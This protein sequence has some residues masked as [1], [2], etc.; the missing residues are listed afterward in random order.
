MVGSNSAQQTVVQDLS[1]CVCDTT[2]NVKLLLKEALGFIETMHCY[3][4]SSLKLV[5]L[6]NQ[7]YT[8]PVENGH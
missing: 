3:G 7:T 2:E 8:S 6:L 1:V 5:L 4:N